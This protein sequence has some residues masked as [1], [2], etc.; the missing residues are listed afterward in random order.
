MELFKAALS[1]LLG[2]KTIKQKEPDG[3]LIGCCKCGEAH[4][5]LRRVKGVKKKNK[6]LYLCPFCKY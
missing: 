5:T 3:N 2:K 4:T 6:S 1:K